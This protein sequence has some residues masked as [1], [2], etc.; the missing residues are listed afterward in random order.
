MQ[1]LSRVLSFAID[2]LGKVTIN[3]CTGIK[4]LYQGDS[5]SI[6]IKQVASREL[7]F[8]VELAAHS[9]LRMADLIRVS[10]SHVREHAIVFATSKS[11][12]RREVIIPL[13]AGLREVLA[14]LPRRATTILTNTLHRPWTAGGL[15]GAFRPAK[16]RSA[17]ADS[18]LHWH[19]LRGTC[20]TKLYLADVSQ[21]AI[22]E[23]LGWDE[24]TVERIIRKY[25]S[26]S[27]ATQ[28]GRS[29]R[30]Q[31]LQ[32]RLQNRSCE[33]PSSY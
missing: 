22:A 29:K 23:I 6:A 32:N 17:I 1:V 21:R 24:A 5:D 8:A 3:P 10:W 19:D 28:S 30:E 13:H 31:K 12:G 18:N 4:R 2:P 16:E 27:A 20:A 15:D 7:G 25:M 11:R 26:C 9:G 14:R 33:H